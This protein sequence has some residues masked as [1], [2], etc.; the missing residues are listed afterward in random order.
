[1]AT[2]PQYPTPDVH[3]LVSRTH[4]YALLPGQGDTGPLGDRHEVKVVRLF[5]KVLNKDKRCD[6]SS[7]LP[8]IQGPLGSTP[9]LLFSL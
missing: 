5:C 1:M 4:G 3:G 9:W 2:P 8:V 6:D 7:D